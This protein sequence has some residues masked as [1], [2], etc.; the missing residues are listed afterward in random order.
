MDA[1]ADIKR[2]DVGAFFGQSDP[3]VAAI[4]SRADRSTGLVVTTV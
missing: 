4:A 1:C 2:D 3:F